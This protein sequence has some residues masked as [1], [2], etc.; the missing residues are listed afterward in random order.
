MH[1]N[2]FGESTDMSKDYQ[3]SAA[4]TATQAVLPCMVGD[5]GIAAKVIPAES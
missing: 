3:A 5:R 1:W 2:I 4:D